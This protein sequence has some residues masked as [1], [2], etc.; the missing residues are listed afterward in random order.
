MMSL[1]R[2]GK[3]LNIELPPTDCVTIGGVIQDQ[4]QRLVTVGDQCHWGPLELHVLDA[5]ER[6]NMLI[7]VTL[8][9]TAEDTQ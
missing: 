8:Q 9:P 6:S 1:R 7:R 4:L 2:L 3:Q 5:P